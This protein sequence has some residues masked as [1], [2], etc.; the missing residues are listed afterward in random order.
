MGLHEAEE[1]DLRK[2]P[3]NL[4]AGCG[5][6]RVH[7][8]GAPLTATTRTKFRAHMFPRTNL[9]HQRT[10]LSTSP[11]LHKHAHHPKV[12]KVDSGADFSICCSSGAGFLCLHVFL[13]AVDVSHIMLFCSFDSLISVLHFYPFSPLITYVH[14]THFYATSLFPRCASWYNSPGWMWHLIQSGNLSLFS[15]F[16]W[17]ETA[18]FP[19]GILV[20]TLHVTPD[21]FCTSRGKG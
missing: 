6:S 1:Y 7:T 12:L 16:A 19:F 17:E 3:T 14:L 20:G 11:R 9:R 13:I 21:F 4:S 15:H 10:T 5:I 8:V 18:R 2:I